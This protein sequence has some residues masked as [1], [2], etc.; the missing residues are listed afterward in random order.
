MGIRVDSELLI[1]SR[2]YLRNESGI[3]MIIRPAWKTQGFRSNQGQI[4]APDLA[5]RTS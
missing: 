4:T 2:G 3:C 1:P 5:E